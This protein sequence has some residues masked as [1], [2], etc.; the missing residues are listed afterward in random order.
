[1]FQSPACH[2]A[3][4]AEGKRGRKQGSKTGMEK[5]NGTSLCFTVQYDKNK[6]KNENK[7]KNKNKIKI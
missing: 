3:C 4:P 7:N 6:N 5:T 1:L 2:R